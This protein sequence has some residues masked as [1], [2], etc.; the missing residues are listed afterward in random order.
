MYLPGDG[1]SGVC[2]TGAPLLTS[3][4]HIA[5]RDLP[6]G[7][8]GLLCSPTSMRCTLTHVGDRGPYG[9]HSLDSHLP[10]HVSPRFTT[11]RPLPV[12]AG[13]VWYQTQVKLRPGWVR[14]GEFDL[15]KRVAERLCLRSFDQLVF[16]HSSWLRVKNNRRPG[17]T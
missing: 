10:T 5:H 4:E 3:D 1:N 13:H 11:P 6:L 7:T 8:H 12:G 14:R 2:A 9:A 15:T 17:E 16:L